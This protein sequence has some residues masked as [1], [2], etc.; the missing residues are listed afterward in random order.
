MRLPMKLGVRYLVT[1]E[2]CARSSPQL[3]DYYQRRLA[4]AEL[5]PPK[6]S[7]STPLAVQICEVRENAY[8]RR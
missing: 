5:E 2:S 3:Y 7:V 6:S 1:V 4:V 8:R